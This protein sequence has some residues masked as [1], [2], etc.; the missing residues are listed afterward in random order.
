MLVIWCNLGGVIH[1][2][3]G[4][5]CCRFG[6]S[7]RGF[8]RIVCK[9]LVLDVQNTAAKTPRKEAASGAVLTYLTSPS[10]KDA[11]WQLLWIIQI[12]V[13]QVCHGIDVV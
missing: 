3:C 4:C 5:G 7:V 9:K 1:M 12:L 13:C 6:D 2:R 10:S 8:A 11:G